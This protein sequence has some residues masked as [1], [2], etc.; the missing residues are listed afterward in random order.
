MPVWAK[1]PAIGN[2]M[3]NARAETIAEKASFKRPLKR[4]R[5]LVIADGFYEWRKDDKGKTPLRIVKKARDPFAFAGLWDTWKNRDNEEIR[6][7]TIITSAT[8][9]FMSQ[10]HHRMPV[11]LRRTDESAWLDPEG[12]PE[13]LVKLL[14]PYEWKDMEYHEVSRL[15][16]SPRNDGHECIAK[17]RHGSN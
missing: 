9:K 2:K 16:N 11:I 15:V 7:F 3:I 13:K 14:E 6:T 8:N 5:C 4:S 12:K 17:S 1:D 10:L